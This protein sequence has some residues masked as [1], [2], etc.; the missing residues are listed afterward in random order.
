MKMTKT[1]THRGWHSRG[2]LPHFGMPGV[3]Q[4][5]TYRL[6]DALPLE[7]VEAIQQDKRW[8]DNLAKRQQIENYLDAGYGECFLRDD[9]V[10]NL[11]EENWLHFDGQRYRLLAWVVMPNHIHV[12]IEVFEGYLLD[13]VVQSW[14]SYTALEANKI[15]NRSGRFWYPDYFDRYI[16]DEN[17][18]G[19]VVRYI[20]NN[21]VKAG[22]ADT[23]E[24]WP[25]SSAKLWQ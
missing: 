7:V 11:V 16:R 15:L 24:L 17:H 5:I 19:N 3:I 1:K 4:S 14:K 2:Y 10:A 8:H 12:L 6:H 13:K 22:L 20:H 25:F 18:F 23:A 21:P 9:R